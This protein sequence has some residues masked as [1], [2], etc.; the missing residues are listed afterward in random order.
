MGTFVC[1]GLWLRGRLRIADGA[2][3]AGFRILDWRL[4]LIGLRIFG[5]FAQ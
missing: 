4:G 2:A 3:M 5:S 1:V